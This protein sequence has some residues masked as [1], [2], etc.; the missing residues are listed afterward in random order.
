[1]TETLL[2]AVGVDAVCDTGKN[3]SG[4]AH[5]WC[6][7]NIGG[8][9]YSFEPQFNSS[10][11][12]VVQGDGAGLGYV[13]TGERRLSTIEKIAPDQKTLSDLTFAKWKK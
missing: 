5:D 13:R 6:G 12:A 11:S 8:V 10:Q 1:M 9:R 3:A 2:L 7:V 4:A